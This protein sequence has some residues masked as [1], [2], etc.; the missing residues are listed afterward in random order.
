M[1]DWHASNGKERAQRDGYYRAIRADIGLLSAANTNRIVSSLLTCRRQERR[2]DPLRRLQHPREPSH[3]P[4]RANELSIS[5]CVRSRWASA[6][7]VMLP[8]PALYLAVAC[9]SVVR[10]AL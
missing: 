3:T 8:R 2:S 1:S 5:A 4:R 9:C 6:T 7:S 10:A